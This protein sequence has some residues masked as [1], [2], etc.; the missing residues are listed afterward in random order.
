[1]YIDDGLGVAKLERQ[2]L[3]V[4]QQLSVFGRER[5]GRRA[6]WS[7]LDRLERFIGAGVGLATPVA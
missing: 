3:V 2:T 6:L 4:A 1:L 5:M 7:A